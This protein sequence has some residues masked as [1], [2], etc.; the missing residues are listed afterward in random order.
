M[1]SKKI[2]IITIIL[3]MA[4]F[5]AVPFSVYAQLPMQLDVELPIE[6]ETAVLLDAHNGQVLYEKDANKPMHPASLTK[7][8]T[9]LLIG[10]AIDDELIR[11]DDT[12]TVSLNAY[13]M[14]IGSRMFL[15]HEQEVSVRDLVKG[16]AIISAND[17]C[18]AMAE[19]IYGSE[20]AFA[21]RMN[22]RAE[23]LGMTNTT[24]RNTHGLHDPEQLMSA[25]DVAIL[26]NYFT[27]T[28]PEIAAYQAEREWTFNEIRQ[29]NRNPLLGRYEGASGIKTG[30]L[31]QAGWCLAG[32][33]ERNGFSLI[34]VV[35]NA[36]DSPSRG[37]DSQVLLN[38]GFNRYDFYREA[39]AGEEVK[40][41]AV[42]RGQTQTVPLVAVKNIDVVIPKDQERF[43]EKELVL[44]D[45]IV[46]PVEEGDILGTLK[47]FYGDDLLLETTLAAG[48]DV[49][50]QGFFAYIGSSIKGFFTDTWQRIVQR[51][52]DSEEEE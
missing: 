30:Y 41:A 17:A 40:T 25:L 22:Q 10:E 46:A 51:I 35:L 42:E 48:E 50:R 26:A 29:Y 6:S 19:H 49:E 4:F 8:M 18:V 14:N 20:E 47:V 43:I 15:E 44:E 1:L 16:I 37:N 32:L 11:W 21:Q 3:I 5:I 34:S 45:K 39:N 28:Q 23:E 33:A 38:H 36:P 52:F 13:R 7:I 9:L 12:V 31:S 24:F 2:R 27:E